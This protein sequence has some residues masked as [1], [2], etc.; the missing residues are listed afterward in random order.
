M[1]ESVVGRNTVFS[2]VTQPQPAFRYPAGNRFE[3]MSCEDLADWAKNIQG[4]TKPGREKIAVFI[5]KENLSGFVLAKM[6]GNID[7]IR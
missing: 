5:V 4:I 7:I 6:G 1:A 2:P 3:D